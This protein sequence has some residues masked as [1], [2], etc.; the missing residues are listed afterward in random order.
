MVATRRRSETSAHCGPTCSPTSSIS[1]PTTALS[2]SGHSSAY[3]TEGVRTVTISRHDHNSP[4]TPLPLGRRMFDRT[5]TTPTTPTGA[6]LH[7]PAY[8]TRVDVKASNWALPIAIHPMAQ[9]QAPAISEGPDR[10]RAAMFQNSRISPAR[11]RD[12]P[13]RRTDRLTPAI[14]EVP[15]RLRA[16]RFQNPRALPTRSRHFPP[17][18]TE[19]R[20]TPVIPT[21]VTRPTTP[22][23][24]AERNPAATVLTSPTGTPAPPQQNRLDRA[25]ALQTSAL[26]KP[27]ASKEWI[28]RNPITALLTPLAIPSPPRQ[29]STKHRRAPSPFVVL[30]TVTATWNLRGGDWAPI[31]DKPAASRPWVPNPHRGGSMWPS[32]CPEQRKVT[33]RGGA[34]SIPAS[35]GS[36]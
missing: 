10:S 1:S 11:S 7:P 25:A 32:L 6:L 29:G 3:G 28:V 4:R 16:A 34:W 31:Y 18:R 27:T 9:L 20:V 17:R 13:T 26:T 2:T 14:T 24:R 15:D 33:V 12:T 23:I 8:Q 36:E 35:V 30:G 22:R 19:N 21:K 5:P